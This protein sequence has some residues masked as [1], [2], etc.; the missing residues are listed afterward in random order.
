MHILKQ[1]KLQNPVAFL[2]EAISL[3]C[4][5]ME[6]CNFTL[7]FFSEFLQQGKI[8]EAGRE[9]SFLISSLAALLVHSSYRCTD[10]FPQYPNV[11]IRL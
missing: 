11:L 9:G 1:D 5:Q 8:A 7:F 6:Q 4:K 10:S 2:Q 3:N